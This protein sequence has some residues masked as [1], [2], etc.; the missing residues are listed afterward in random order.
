MIYEASFWRDREDVARLVDGREREARPRDVECGRGAVVG[1]LIVVD[2]VLY[3]ETSE[4][5]RMWVVAG[6]P[7]E[8]GDQ[9]LLLYLF[10]FSFK[11]PHVDPSVVPE[12]DDLR[13]RHGT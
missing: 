4:P 11:R 5:T 12:C 3:E 6:Q 9:G 7:G 1:A 2:A 10:G 13:Q 8:P